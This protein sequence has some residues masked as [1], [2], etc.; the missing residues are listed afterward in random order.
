MRRTIV[1]SL[2]AIL[3]YSPAF[4]CLG[5]QFEDHHYPSCTIPL[6]ESHERVSVIH[7]GG[8]AELSDHHLGEANSRTRLVTVHVEENDAQNY[9][10]LSSREQTIWRLTGDVGSVSRAVVLGATRIGPDGAGV[11]GLPEDRISFTSPDLTAL[12]SVLQTS[13]TRVANACTPAQWFGDGLN[14]RTSLHPETTQPRQ[15][16]DEFVSWQ[17]RMRDTSPRTIS[18]VPPEIPDAMISVSPETIVSQNP[19]Q[20]Y[21]MLPGRPGLEAL[22]TSGALVPMN[23]D[24]SKQIVQT[25]AEK[26]SARYQSRFDPNFFLIPT[27]DYIVTKEITL[28]PEL[29]PTA[30]MVASGIPAPKMNGNRGYTVCLYF[31]EQ[32]NQRVTGPGINSNLCRLNSISRAVPDDEQDI[33]RAAASFDRMDAG[34]QDCQMIS[35]EDG[36]R[37]AAIALSEGQFRRYRDDPIRQINIEVTREEPTALFLSMEGG[38]VQ[39]NISG[40]QVVAV[41]SRGGPSLG[42]ADVTLNGSPYEYSRLRSPDETCPQ[43]APLFPN[44]LGPSIAHLDELFELLTAQRIDELIT[45]TETDRAWRS[46][47]SP[48]PVYVID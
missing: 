21:E 45:F 32:A 10:V 25:Y 33:L 19:A 7:G 24:Q 15:R 13:C 5:P 14:E 39:W 16:V 42:L 22:V 12:D 26:L 11:I 43:F 47:N 44:R 20:A 40:T 30:L 1:I 6:P 36:T 2:L 29:P 17:S 9:F 23:S 4:A 28:P 38:P 27:I 37:I 35:F 46:P 3:S 41:Y 8:A 31:E 18:I 48:T 34:S